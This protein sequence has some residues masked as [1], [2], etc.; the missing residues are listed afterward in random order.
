MWLALRAVFWTL[1][2]PGLTAF[3]L[4]WRYFGLREVRIDISSCSR[5]SGNLRDAAVARC[6]RPIRRAI[7]W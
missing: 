4:P 3:Y 1:L 7:S 2:L 5:V 6:R